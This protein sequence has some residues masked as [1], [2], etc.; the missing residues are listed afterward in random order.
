MKNWKKAD[1]YSE[2]GARQ[3]VNCAYCKFA[4]FFFLHFQRT[5]AYAIFAALPA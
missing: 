5:N 3:E 4:Y 2:I 1:G